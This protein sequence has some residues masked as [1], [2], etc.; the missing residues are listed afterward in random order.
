MRI[1]LVDDHALVRE[2]VR[3]LLASQ[4]TLEVVGEA[5]QAD[6]AL[7][8]VAELHPDLVL[9]DI[10][11]KQTNG[12]HLTA[13]LMQRHPGLAV[14]MLSM[15]DN[16]EYVHQAL[17][18][19]ARGYVLKNGPSSE[20]FAAIE[21]I[22]A[23]GSYLSAEL[24]RSAGARS[25]DPR[26]LISERESEI[27]NGLARG[28]SSKQIAALFDL[29]VRTVETHRQNIRR[30]LKIAGQAELIRYAVERCR[31]HGEPASGD[32]LR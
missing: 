31:T 16:P 23:G 21:A 25:D 26:P 7:L 18:A 1:V 29:S 20:I 19:G 32:P 11:M 12:I 28:L 13:E 3:A 14:L 6:E 22:A 4:P 8:R 30:K 5:A 17:Q 15:Y 10:G 27:L 2:G 9:M 24:T